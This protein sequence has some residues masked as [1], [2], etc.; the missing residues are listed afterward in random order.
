MHTGDTV[1]KLSDIKIRYINGHLKGRDILDVGSGY[2]YYSEWLATNNSNLRVIALDQLDLM[3][4]KGV[5]FVKADLEQPIPFP[6][7][8]FDT[9]LVFDVIEHIVHEE[10][11]L[12]ELHRICRP[13]GVIIGSVPHSDDYFLPAYNLTFYNRTDMT[14]KRYY[15]ID[16][17]KRL[18]NNH[19]FDVV[20]VDAQGI[21][22]PNLFA[23]FFPRLIKPLVKKGIG[24]LRRMRVINPYILSSDLFF[25]AQKSTHYKG[26]K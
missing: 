7:D 5:E 3:S 6:R 1:N 8:Y 24:L 17:L 9:I 15:A 13:S 16:T 19:G 26:I 18:L 10:S 11:L 14:H 20:T 23:E 4:C 22:P 25:V 12:D 2:A 21:V